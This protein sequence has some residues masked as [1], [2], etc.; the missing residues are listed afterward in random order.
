MVDLVER[1]D[2][3]RGVP[4]VGDRAMGHASA[5]AR[6]VA[7]GLRFLTA[8]RVTEI[9]TYTEDLPSDAFADIIPGGTELSHEIDVERAR[10][11]AVA[12]GLEQVDDFLFRRCHIAQFARRTG[13]GA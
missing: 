9:G 6:L 5:V 10:T 12:A 11:T 1:V 13:R 7:S 2:W 4:F 8:T 3:V